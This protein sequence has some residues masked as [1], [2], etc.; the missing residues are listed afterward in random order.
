MF[1]VDYIEILY[2][3]V[4]NRYISPWSARKMKRKNVSV[5][6][7]TKNGTKLLTIVKLVFNSTIRL[8]NIDINIW[9]ATQINWTVNKAN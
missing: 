6:N 3:V 4:R 5:F 8:V 2:E 9:V 7:Q 1:G